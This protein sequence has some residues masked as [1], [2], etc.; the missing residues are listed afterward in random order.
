MDTESVSAGLGVYREPIIFRLAA[1]TAGF[2]PEELSAISAQN[3]TR[4]TREHYCQA[5]RTILEYIAAGDTYQVNY[6]FKFSFDFN[7]SASR[8]ST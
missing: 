6:T 3:L 1:V 2:R 7:G 8:F 4:M 5:I